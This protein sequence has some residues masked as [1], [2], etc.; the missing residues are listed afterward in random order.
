MERGQKAAKKPP[1]AIR[2][3]SKDSS[4]PSYSGA[5]VGIPLDRRRLYVDQQQEGPGGVLVAAALAVASAGAFAQDRYDRSLRRSS[6]DQRTTNMTIAMT[7]MATARTTTR[8][9]RRAA[10]GHAGSR[11]HAAAANAGTKR[12]Y[13]Q[14][15]YGGPAAAHVAGGAVLGG[16]VGAVIGHQIGHGDGR[17]AATAAGAVVGAA[18][19]T[20][21]AQRRAGYAVGAAARVHG[22]ALRDAL[23]RRVAGAHRRLP[24][25]LRVQRPPP[26]DRAAVSPRRPHPRAG[27]RE[28]GASSDTS[29]LPW[30]CGRPSTAKAA[31][32]A[33]SAA[34]R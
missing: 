25:D 31:R 32:I 16:I 7:T 26:G 5:T 8:G 30:R 23:P 15:G 22:A 4:T 18:I 28:P 6:D 12:A 21:Q 24:R 9:H 34:N 10:A 19:G 13:D 3:F 11:Q 14:R 20:Q 27:R 2:A 29:C 17:R 1:I 33:V